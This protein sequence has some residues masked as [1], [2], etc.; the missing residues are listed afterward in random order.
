MTS[1][2]PFIS[3]TG[4]W[5]CRTGRRPCGRSS[6]CQFLTRA[7]CRAPRCRNSRWRSFANSGSTA[8]RRSRL[9]EED[10][11][12]ERLQLVVRGGPTDAE[13]RAAFALEVAQAE[14]VNSAT[15]RN[16]TLDPLRCVVAVVV[17]HHFV[18]DGQHRSV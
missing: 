6:T 15:Q 3:P 7:G 5:C 4:S 17:D 2:R 10:R 14:L 18:V 12:G 16:V 1:R 13:R 8:P 11:A 9:V